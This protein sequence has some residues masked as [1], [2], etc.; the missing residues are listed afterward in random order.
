MWRWR[1]YGQHWLLDEDGAESG[2]EAGVLCCRAIRGVAGDFLWGTPEVPTLPFGVLI[3]G[4]E[5]N[6]QGCNASTSR[7]LF[8]WASSACFCA[9]FPSLSLTSSCYTCMCVWFLL[10]RFLDQWRGCN[11]VVRGCRCLTVDKVGRI[12]HEGKLDVDVED[13][14]SS[15]S[16]AFYRWEK[17]SLHLKLLVHGLHVY[18]EVMSMWNSNTLPTKPRGN[19]VGQF[20]IVSMTCAACINS[21]EGILKDFPVATL[22]SRCPT[23]CWFCLWKL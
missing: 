19:L 7:Y 16:H 12:F 10:C 22:L 9:H 2:S 17:I 3:W 8:G 14:R 5:D 20:T 1:R 21:V 6:G 23:A 18:T 4:K 13:S 15:A 11:E